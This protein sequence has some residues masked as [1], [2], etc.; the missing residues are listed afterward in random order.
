[1]A[2]FLDNLFQGNFSFKVLFQHSGQG[3]LH[4]WASRR[5]LGVH[6]VFFLARMRRV[7]RGDNIESIIQQGI[8]QLISVFR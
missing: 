7:V 4:Q 2:H 1:M 5:G 3:M 6:I 8:P